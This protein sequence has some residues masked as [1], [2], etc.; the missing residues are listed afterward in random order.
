MITGVLVQFFLCCCPAA[1]MEMDK[2]NEG[3]I[4]EIH[5]S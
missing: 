2:V 3:L 4:Q 5:N 1:G